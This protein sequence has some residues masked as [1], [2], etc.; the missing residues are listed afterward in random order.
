MAPR[1]SAR[2]GGIA[3]VAHYLPACSIT[4]DSLR[5]AWGGGGARD[6]SGLTIADIDEDALPMA[7][8]GGQ[9][10]LALWRVRPSAVG[11]VRLGLPLGREVPTSTLAGALALNVAP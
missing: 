11:W 7:R 2:K 9:G 3:A 4:P 1:S 6:I 5:A 8:A 10:C